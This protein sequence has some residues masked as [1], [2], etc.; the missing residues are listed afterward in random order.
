MLQLSQK[1]GLLTINFALNV[2]RVGRTASQVQ[3]LQIQVVLTVS[4]CRVSMPR[5]SVLFKWTLKAYLRRI[6]R[7]TRGVSRDKDGGIRIA[8]RVAAIDVVAALKVV[9]LGFWEVC[10]SAI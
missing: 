5:N 9:V 8:G 2:V 3:S 6:D 4:T 7:A 10:E 1:E